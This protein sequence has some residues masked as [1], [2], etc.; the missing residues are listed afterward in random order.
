MSIDKKAEKKKQAVVTKK[1]AAEIKDIHKADFKHQKEFGEPITKEALMKLERLIPVLRNDAKRLGIQQITVQIVPEKDLDYVASVG[2]IGYNVI[3]DG[4]FATPGGV[5]YGYDAVEELTETELRA[6]A[7]HEFGHLI[8]GYFFPSSYARDDDEL[9]HYT[10]QETFCDEFAYRK[11]GD[12]L[13]RAQLKLEGEDTKEKSDIL[14][15]LYGMKNFK[16]K[17]GKHEYWL[18]LA[19]AY[20]IRD[21]IIYDPENNGMFGVRPKRRILKGMYS[22]H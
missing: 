11:F 5:Q 22:E 6:M 17:Y 19:E 4:V 2:E 15:K 20:G 9:E 18:S 16:K 13:L 3:G 7:W 8:Y 10:V 14:K 21:E 1:E 12:I